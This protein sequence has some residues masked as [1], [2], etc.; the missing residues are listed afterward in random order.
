MY[1]DFDTLN[2]NARI[3]IYQSDR[4]LLQKEITDMSSDLK[5]FLEDWKAHGKDL[6]ASFKF[7]FGHFLV[8]GVDEHLNDASGC[9]I[10]A[11]VHFI[12]Q[13]EQKYK[14]SFFDR[15]KIAFMING[16]T[17]LEDLSEI[18]E[19]VI[20]GVI[21]AETMTFNNLIDRKEL[22]N[23]Q[24]LL[25]AANTWMKKLFKKSTKFEHNQ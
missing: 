18:K 12:K 20:S 3:W 7:Y 23:S 14:T 17:C 11:S 15:T 22:L 19:K 24:W 4:E 9:S 1:T 8:L 5:T 2:S 16:K 21:H 6:N 13:I 10:D 25:P